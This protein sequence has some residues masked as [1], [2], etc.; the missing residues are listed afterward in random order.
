MGF[1]VLFVVV[2][3]TRVL[4]RDALLG[5]LVAALLLY[6][7]KFGFALYVTSFSTYTLIYGAFAAIP[8]F[9]L[10]VYF[11][12]LSVLLGA[13]VAASLPLLRKQ[14]LQLAGSTTEEK[15]ATGQ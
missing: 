8:V 13:H 6:V 11:S 3:N 12:W 1:T 2:P 14:T 9:L 4:W 15:N 7:M 10:W 5:G